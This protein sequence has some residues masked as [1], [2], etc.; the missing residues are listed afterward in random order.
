M[1][2]LKYL[3]LLLLAV[4]LVVGL[5]AC[6]TAMVDPDDM[7][8]VPEL[9][10]SF[11]VTFADQNGNVIKTQQVREGEAATPPSDAKVPEVPD[12][13]FVGWDADINAITGDI[14]VRP[15]YEKIRFAVEFHAQDG[16]LL[17]GVKVDR[18][19]TPAAPQTAQIE[20]YHF[21]GW[22]DGTTL[23][24]EV[25]VP[26]DD[27]TLFATYEI[28]LYEVTFVDAL[29]EV[30]TT[31]AHG[32]DATAPEAR[33]PAGKRFDGWDA[34]FTSVTG[35][36]TVNARYVTVHTVTFVDWD[37]TPIGAPQVIDEGTDAVPPADPARAGHT[38]TGWD[39]NFTNVGT[40]IEVKAL[41]TINQY[42][43]TFLDADGT[44]L[45]V[46]TTDY[47][48]AVIAPVA[49]A[50][51][52]MLFVRWVDEAGREVSDFSFTA[53]D[54][55]VKA[56]YARAITVV[57]MSRDGAELAR[58]VVPEG[59]SVTAPDAPTIEGMRF[60]GWD[61][62]YENVTE[63]VTATAQYVKIWTVIFVDYDGTQL[64]D[65]QIVDEGT[66]AT[67]PADPANKEGH[68]FTAW[69]TAFDAVTSD[70][71]VKALYEI[72]TY[73]VRFVD[74]MGNE[75]CA[76]QTINWNAAAAAPD[77]PARVDWT[78]A[79]WDRDFAAVTEDMTVTATYTP[80]FNPIYN[81]EDLANLKN[82][83]SGSFWGLM[84]DIEVDNKWA[85]VVLPAGVTFTGDGHTVSG[86]TKPLFSTIS[87]ENTVKNLTVSGTVSLTTSAGMLATDIKGST[88]IANV[89]A[90]GSVT[91]TNAGGIVANVTGNVA[92][93]VTF[94]N[95]T[96]NATVTSTSGRA[97]GILATISGS[98]VTSAVN[99]ASC[100][101]NGTVTAKTNAGG[102]LGY[103][104]RCGDVNLDNCEN[105]AVIT[106]AN[107]VGGLVGASSSGTNPCNRLTITYSTND[108][109]ITG[110]TYVGGLVGQLD[111][112][113]APVTIENCVNLGNVTGE[114][115]VGGV[116]GYSWSSNNGNSVLYLRGVS[117]YADVTATKDYAGG[118]IGR[119]GLRSNAAGLQ[120]VFE[121]CLVSGTVT[122]PDAAAAVLGGYYKEGKSPTQD[123]SISLSSCVFDVI[124][125]CEGQKAA[126]VGKYEYKTN[127]YTLTVTGADT[128][129]FTEALASGVTYYNSTGAVK[130]EGLAAGAPTLEYFN[131]MAQSV[132]N[133]NTW[134]ASRWVNVD[135]K[136][137][138]RA[139]AYTYYFCGE[140]GKLL[141][142][143]T[144]D[145]EAHVTFPRTG[146]SEGAAIS[147][148]VGY[149]ISAWT[150]GGTEY[151]AAN[152]FKDLT[153]NSDK[154][155]VASAY[156]PYKYTI[157]FNNAGNKKIT[158]FSVDYGSFVTAAQLA[159]VTVPEIEGK[160]FVGWT[161]SGKLYTNDEVLAMA[162]PGAV[163]FKATYEDQMVVV[164]KDTDGAVLDTKYVAS[165][166]TATAPADP[167]K[168][169]HTFSGWTDGTNTYTKE[170]IDAMAVSANVTYTAV[171][172]PFTYTVIFRDK[173][174]V[175]L[176]ETQTV[177]WGTAAT[178]PEVPAIPG[179]T[180]D[181]WF[182]GETQI[183]N[184]M[185]S[186]V[187][188]NYDVT[189][190]YSVS[191]YT[192]SFESDGVSVGDPQTVVHGAFATAPAD[193]TKEGYTF[194]GW[195]DGET[196]YT[197]AQI[198]ARAVTG[199]VTYTAVWQII[200][201]TVTF[202]DTDGVTVLW[203]GDVAYGSHL[204]APTDYTL[205]AGMGFAGWSADGG[206][207]L[208][209]ADDLAET[210]TVTGAVTFTAYASTSCHV[211]FTDE[212]YTGA[213]GGLI[214]EM[215]VGQGGS[216]VAPADPDNRYNYH[217]VG[218]SDGT[219]T[220][221]AEQVEALVIETDVAFTAVYAIND[222]T[223]IFKNWDGTQIGE[224]Q[225]VPHGADAAAP[226][227]PSRE[228]W[229]F[230]SWD[231]DIAN[232]TE[233]TVITAVFEP[234]F[235]SIST[236]EELAA[237]ATAA[238]GSFYGL[239]QNIELSGWTPITLPE[240][241]K[242]TGAG[243]TISGLTTP[244]FAEISTGTTIKLL[245]VSA[246]ISGGYPTAG[247]LSVNATGNVTLDRVTT[248]GSVY[249]TQKSGGLLGTYTG[250]AD[251]Q[252]QIMGCAN[253]ASVTV[254]NG[255]SSAGGIIAETAAASVTN[256]SNT[257]NHGAISGNGTS[258]FLGGLVGNLNGSKNDMTIENCA[259]YG[260]VTDTKA[261]AIAAGAVARNYRG[262]SITITGFVNAAD[263]TISAPLGIAAGL[264]GDVSSG[265]SAGSAKLTA[266]DVQN[267]ASVTG[268]KAG[269]ILAT[270]T[271]ALQAI[272]LTRVE[273][274][275]A[276]NGT[277]YAGGIV[278]SHEAGNNKNSPLYIYD[279]VND[280]TV[281]VTANESYAGGIIGRLMI[282]AGSGFK[283]TGCSSLGDVVAPN[284]ET[285]KGNAGGIIGLLHSTTNNYKPVL[286]GL[287]V[288]CNVTG[289]YAGGIV[290]EVLMQQR[291]DDYG[292]A[293][294]YT[295]IG[296]HYGATGYNLNLAI[297]NS[298]VTVTLTGTRTA[299]VVGVFNSNA[300]L[301]ITASGNTWST[302]TTV[303]YNSQAFVAGE[304]ITYWKRGA[305]ASSTMV[306]Y[307]ISGTFVEH[308]DA[309]Q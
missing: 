273:N 268:S 119:V 220:Y 260:T 249:A 236:Q 98:K 112:A 76:P 164:F 42:T 66:A 207:T 261:N 92:T 89:T 51:E 73:T 275:G 172:T 145:D 237:L 299:S 83:A 187:K 8:D 113:N 202:L 19:Q 3:S 171:W 200:T 121:G 154:I 262:G 71:T 122:A 123:V 305:S 238:S 247:I 31:V 64:G 59:S 213:E 277:T 270:S 209:S 105:R 134:A 60:T 56:V 167:E 290:G 266:T 169:G 163:T 189:A 103:A 29:G 211:T 227:D 44:E 253:Y 256:I 78:F 272:T 131:A 206:V 88:L 140:D 295:V 128:C 75:L 304:E 250:S 52:G 232:I 265:S 279:S 82:A 198:D 90:E 155:V 77:A 287:T 108:A 292:A 181:G 111:G 158:S 306:E 229:N 133:A 174:G 115:H 120:T 143:R 234:A 45:K 26:T 27:M 283:A 186:A 130:T 298:S 97:G 235:T 2:H 12:H 284:T 32:S 62:G 142:V 55:T 5:T 228:D 297:S 176:G 289:A 1:K 11:T 148:R 63:N 127:N 53:A 95:C 241:V 81:Q 222:H 180:F 18:G 117:V 151:T 36:L 210:Y 150:V 50:P 48:T 68:H 218:W 91:G 15:V 219:N 132:N 125:N 208:Y 41:Y 258:A 126:I 293:K 244:L 138:P 34:D 153:T 233:D 199:N 192:V 25:P 204:T 135:G 86:L 173:D 251:T 170:Q 24:P 107:G 178:L 22:S 10:Q 280:A 217:F 67:A 124:L 9:P 252:L 109:A 230:V 188:A 264:V 248:Q 93:V 300:A 30:K 205:G 195:S 7:P 168:E 137:L 106:G 184:D 191:R 40:D 74:W 102:I 257:Q 96:N 157:Q 61:N 4:V 214:A 6:S 175:Q 193:P 72:N 146:T 309:V 302:G 37:G 226:A 21:V 17:A 46:K 197:K 118:M 255:N 281:T 165:G 104:Y 183:T 100:V 99:F 194:L 291:E 43:V 296:Y 212:Y 201:Y 54:L 301:T 47:G 267:H 141:L 221:T 231:K 156:T 85:S 161:Y 285:E 162:V 269:G 225:T 216:V 38:F 139:H 110:T 259:N 49:N 28:N 246:T 245:T 308:T 160:V 94:L 14:T 159:K 16:L 179:Y 239:T 263:A 84:G 116:A 177:N 196:T 271:T 307:L 33:V 101:N 69:D 70:L 288:N 58:F 13:A 136:L 215:Y 203:T 80:N 185:L 254:N 166:A 282:W 276:V 286:D 274:H 147:D 223:V 87:G 278:G 39:K 224:A 149:G 129:L 23:Y 240:G 20:G 303:T 57:F 182:T 144:V 294:K 152:G 65:A 243:Y 190:R 242:F 114:T 79:R 35:N